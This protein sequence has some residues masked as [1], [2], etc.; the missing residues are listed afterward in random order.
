M[1]K[2]LVP[3][4]FSSVADVAIHYA[5]DLSKTLHTEV[6][7]LHVVKKESEVD[8]AVLKLNELCARHRSESNY[9]LKY[10]TK[11]G[12]IFDDIAQVAKDANAELVVMGTH[13][14]QGLQY[15][16]G[17]NALRVVSEN[18]AP[19]IIVQEKSSTIAQV[20]K[21]LVPLDLHKD[22]KQK[23]KT[24][25]EIA[26]KFNSEVH[27][28][29]PKESDEFLHNQIARNVSYAEGFLEQNNIPYKTQITQAS[30]S[31]FVKE[32]LLFAAHA[33]ID[34]ICILNN[35]DEQLIHAFGIDSEQ[36][37]ITND[38]FIP[39]MILNPASTY[40]DAR[41]IFAQ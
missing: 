21:L 29:A 11:V 10:I 3:T 27:I 6:H 24:V 23:L 9:D 20:K 38:S 25:L 18:S 36:K 22:T 39:V 26:K 41:S 2:I 28:L 16:V 17:S 31:G 14:L 1:K 5:C 30:S 4:D 32:L 33:E 37:I 12:N 19:I 35:T 13:G 34:L 15:L 40:V 7:L 8:A